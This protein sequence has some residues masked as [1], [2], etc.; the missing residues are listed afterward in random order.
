MLL[1]GAAL[2]VAP[3][4]MIPSWAWTLTPSTSAAAGAW[5]IGIGLTALW[6]V[7]E[8]DWQ[9]VRGAMRSY[10]LLGILQF[11]ALG[12]YAAQVDWS[13]W[14]ALVYVA[15]LLSILVVGALGVYF[16]RKRV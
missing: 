1:V 13:K 15:F 14:A 11:V 9:R 2:Y 4:L 7:W 10:A 16:A 8:N 3:A 12:R 5:C 6:G